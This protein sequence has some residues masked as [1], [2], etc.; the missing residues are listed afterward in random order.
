MGE[1]NM[2]HEVSDNY[3]KPILLS[4]FDLSEHNFSTQW[5]NGF[6]THPI[7]QSIILINHDL[8]LVEKQLFI[9]F[10]YIQLPNSL[11]QRESFREINKEIKAHIFKDWNFTQRVYPI[12]NYLRL[13]SAD[14]TTQKYIF[15]YLSPNISPHVFDFEQIPEKDNLTKNILEL[16]VKARFLEDMNQNNPLSVDMCLGKIFLN[17]VINHNEKLEKY[18]ANVFSYRLYFKDKKLGFNLK[19]EHFLLDPDKSDIQLYDDISLINNYK[20]KHKEDARE[21]GRPFLDFRN[22]EKLKSTKFATQ[23]QLY[24]II[25][26]TLNTFKIQHKNT[27]FESQFLYRDFSSFQN[28][29]KDL[30]I[31]ISEGEKNSYEQDLMGKGIKNGIESLRTYLKKTFNIS[32]HLLINPTLNTILMNKDKHNLFLMYG[33]EYKENYVSEYLPEG[34]NKWQDPVLPF[35]EREMFNLEE[36]NFLKKIIYFDIYS[37]VK[38]FNIYANI[39]AEAPIVSQGL[40]LDKSII[41]EEPSGELGDDTNERDTENYIELENVG[42]NS[43][44]KPY[45]RNA[46]KS[47][48]SKIVN[49]LNIKYNLFVKKSVSFS[50]GFTI[51]KAT[52]NFNDI[53]VIQKLSKHNHTLYAVLDVQ[54]ADIV[55][56]GKIYFN[57]ISQKILLSQNISTLNADIDIEEELKK[58]DN[59]IIID[60]N[61]LIKVKNN[62][63]MPFIILQRDNLHDAEKDPLLLIDK[64]IA[65]GTSASTGVSKSTG[66]TT[67]LFFPY[68]TPVINKIVKQKIKNATGYCYC[69]LHFNQGELNIYMNL[70][71]AGIQATMAKNNRLENIE[72]FQIKDFCS[73]KIS[74]QSHEQILYFYLSTLTFNYLSVNELSKKSLLNKLTDTLLVN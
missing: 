54:R 61:Y 20:Y 62:N 68:N 65:Q 4:E 31:Y 59:L 47:I 40:I 6:F 51:D 16:L 21:Y 14:N 49:E 70:T 15:F 37:Q 64:Y 73:E 26:Q 34:V 17:T 45:P 5:L 8:T 28:E 42:K 52:T 11:D 69:L 22:Y 35:L 46:T 19:N 10:S 30:N 48:I 3:K 63:D 18:F 72:L 24:K 9:N 58:T 74:W 23:I 39:R 56:N 38:L 33:A 32:S 29:I 43:K 67:N 71:N 1:F 55:D 57:V 2:K 7:A 44:T 27:F 25:Q 66:E 12:Y 50:K 41:L 60:N 53:K 36:D 13:I